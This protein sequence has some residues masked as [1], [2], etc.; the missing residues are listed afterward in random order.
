MAR[1]KDQVPSNYLTAKDVMAEFGGIC[2]M[3]LS[4]WLADEQLDFP[5]PIYIKRRRYFGMEDIERFKQKA[6]TGATRSPA[7]S[8]K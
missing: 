6:A 7:A 8:R 5:R 2:E 3:T 4:R 1:R